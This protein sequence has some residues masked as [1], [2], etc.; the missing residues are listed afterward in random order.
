MHGKHLGGFLFIVG[1][2]VTSHPARAQDP[3]LGGACCADPN[4][5]VVLD[6][7]TLAG[8]TV[9][10]LLSC[11]YR[12]GTYCAGGD[13]ATYESPCPTGTCGLNFCASTKTPADALNS[14]DHHSL[15]STSTPKV[16]DFLGPVNTVYHFMA[17]D[18]APV[19]EEGIESTIW[20]SN[21]CDITNFPAG[22][23][24]ATLTT[25]WKKGWE[26]PVA[27][28]PGPNADDYVGQYT[29]AGSGFRYIAAHA[30]NSV[31]IFDDPS[32]TGA[33]TDDDSRPDIPGWQS[34]DDET[35]AIGVPL[36]EADAVIARATDPAAEVFTQVCLDASGSSAASGIATF[37]W[38][39]DGDGVIDATGPEACVTCDELGDHVVTV[40]V[41]DNCGCVDVAFPTYYCLPPDNRSSASQKGS[42]LVYPKIELKWTCTLATP[43]VCTLKQDTFLTIINDYP[44]DVRVKWLFVNG[45]PP[46]DEVRSSAPPFS[47]IERAHEGWNAYNCEPLLTE[48]E[49]TYISMATGLPMGCQPFTINDPGTPPGRPDPDGPP[50]SRMLRGYAIAIAVDNEGRE[51]CWDHLSG[52]GTLVDYVLPTAWEYGAEAYQTVRRQVLE[53]GC[54]NPFTCD[55]TE[56]TLCGTPPDDGVCVCFKRPDGTGACATAG[57]PCETSTLCPNGDSDCPPGQKCFIDTCCFAPVCRPNCSGLPVAELV[58]CSPGDPMPGP[59]G[60]L[61][62][63]GVDYDNCSDKLLFDFFSVGSTALSRPALGVTVTLDTDLTLLPLSADLR[64]DVEG[65]G[66]VTTKAKFDIWNENEDFLSGT[67]RCI[68]CWDQA[69]LSTYDPPNNF[70]LTNLQTNKGKA[71]IDGVASEVCE[72]CE[73]IRVCG[74]APP[75]TCQWIEVCEF[76]SESACLLGAAAKVMAY[77]GTVTGTEYSGNNLVGQG[78][79]SATIL[80][81]VR[82]GPDTLNN[83]RGSNRAPLSQPEGARLSLPKQPAGVRRTDIETQR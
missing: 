8:Q 18:H 62:L 28:Q 37:S 9:D 19:P 32:H 53:K 26:D 43:P 71:R 34:F 1:A 38:D 75:F 65:R 40:F 50:G 56:P 46:A 13:V 55:I 44:E 30:N 79:D 23:T 66:P 82:G 61:H 36:C 60:E 76:E 21:S 14:L 20:G 70:L 15:Q 74:D 68:T 25:I 41:T 83:P 48:D 24:L 69:L 11:D 16:V 27:C 58:A 81:D 42:V 33:S 63:D 35:D 39:L 64:Q 45:D 10:A 2:A 67:T 3:C 12:L 54:D 59:D 52:S 4:A 77:S 22:W 47:I 31:S 72:N 7:V 80:F 49:S 5:C 6:R 29:F 57:L 17:I 51:I 73:F 78:R